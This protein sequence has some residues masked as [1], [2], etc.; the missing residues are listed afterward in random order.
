MN[1][2]RVGDIITRFNWGTSYRVAGVNPYLE[3]T[4]DLIDTGNTYN[5]EPIYGWH[6][7]SGLAGLTILYRDCEDI[8]PDP[9]KTAV[10]RKIAFMD[11]RFASRH[12][13]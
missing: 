3:D 9:N 1:R 11:K 12:V 7:S 8:P 2:L 10:E 13:S 6:Y 5:Y 4:Y